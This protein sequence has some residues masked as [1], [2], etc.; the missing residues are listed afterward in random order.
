MTDPVNI[1]KPATL[2][3]AILKTITNDIH[4]LSKE[5]MKEPG[6]NLFGA[7]ILRKSDLSLVIAG[8]NHESTSPLNH[9]E[10]YAI[11]QFYALP[12]ER[13]PEAKDCLFFST[14]EPCS[15]CVNGIVWGEF[16]N[17]VYMWEYDETDKLFGVR[18]DLNIW[19][20]CFHEGIDQDGNKE[21]YKKRNV[22]FVA[23]SVAE[24]VAAVE[25]S[26]VRSAVAEEVERVKREYGS[27]SPRFRQRTGLAGDG[28]K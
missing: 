4:P 28:L 16:D 9:G 20:D 23:R 12:A 24:L 8:T 18:G 1:G 25:D 21:L 6:S 15:L 5:A 11:N 19:N 3:R 13:R 27:L 17:F 10:T 2:I 7:A 14:H 22:R 26:E